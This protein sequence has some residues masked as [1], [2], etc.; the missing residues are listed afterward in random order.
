MPRT[1][2][3]ANIPLTVSFDSFHLLPFP[4]YMCQAFPL[5][6]LQSRSS[7]IRAGSGEVSRIYVD[8]GRT[9]MKLHTRYLCWPAPS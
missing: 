7:S 9:T 5:P 1:A 3:P 6:L 8:R 2:L 4:L